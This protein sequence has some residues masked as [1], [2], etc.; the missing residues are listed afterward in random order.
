[1]KKVNYP[2]GL[3]ITPINFPILQKMCDLT[4]DLKFH[5]TYTNK[6]LGAAIGGYGK[7]QTM[8]TTLQIRKSLQNP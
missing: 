4:R 6:E 7:F 2:Y 8:T 5:V 3:L 1:M